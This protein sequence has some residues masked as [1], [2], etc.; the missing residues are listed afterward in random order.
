M[1]CKEEFEDRTGK[2]IV[3]RRPGSIW[4]VYG[5]GEYLPPVQADVLRK[6]HAVFSNDSWNV[7]IFSLQPLL[8]VSFSFSYA[9]TL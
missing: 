9:L 5:P 1:C 7:K 4:V 8:I 6:W 2:S 3:R